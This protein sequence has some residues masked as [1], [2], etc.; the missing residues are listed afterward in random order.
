MNKS[1]LAG[2][3]GEQVRLG[4]A[5]SKC[6]TNSR[7]GSGVGPEKWVDFEK[8]DGFASTH[9]KKL[10]PSPNFN[11]SLPQG[12]FLKPEVPPSAL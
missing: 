5:I 12:L 11:F 9:W 7:T 3:D 6:K 1:V 10:H 8:V 2:C 4:T